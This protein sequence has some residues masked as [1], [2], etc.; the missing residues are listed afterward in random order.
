[1]EKTEK[2]REIVAAGATCLTDAD[3]EFIKAEAEACGLDFTPRA[4][5]KN[6]YIDTALQLWKMYREALPDTEKGDGRK[7]VLKAGTAVIWEGIHINEAT[8]TDERAAEW[9]AWGF[10]L[11]YFARYPKNE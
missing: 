7:Y 2:L 9:V 4:R 11:M 3:K 1:M 10:P 8:C 6:C 5:C